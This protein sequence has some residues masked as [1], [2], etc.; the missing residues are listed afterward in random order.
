[1]RIINEVLDELVETESA[2]TVMEFLQSTRKFISELQKRE[3]AEAP[4]DGDKDSQ[5]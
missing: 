4:R 3:N 2:E 5:T 1:M